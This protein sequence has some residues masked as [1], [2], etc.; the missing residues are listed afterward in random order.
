[1]F[2]LSQNEHATKALRSGAKAA[3]IGGYFHHTEAA[4]FGLNDD[5]SAYLY[6]KAM[7]HQIHALAFISGKALSGKAW[8]DW[9]FFVRAVVAGISEGDKEFGL[10]V[11][12]LVPV[13]FKRI[14][15]FQSMPTSST[16]ETY[17]DSAKRV[18]ERDHRADEAAICDALE[19]ATMKYLAN[20]VRM[21][22]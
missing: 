10:S 2:G 17:V 21:F 11:S 3:M 16:R 12:P 20:V 7:V 9:D 14:M 5:A 1:M 15:E 8:A 13:I 19:G 6:T 22:E 18:K 4:Q